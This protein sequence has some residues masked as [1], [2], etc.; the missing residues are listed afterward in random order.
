MHGGFLLPSGKNSMVACTVLV[1]DRV[2]VGSNST[3]P[4]SW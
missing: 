4:A 2:L 1:L 3:V